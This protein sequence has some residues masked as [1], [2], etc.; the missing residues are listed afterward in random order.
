MALY[1]S[2]L[3]VSAYLTTKS[4]LEICGDELPEVYAYHALFCLYIENEKEYIKYRKIAF[5]KSPHAAEMLLGNVKPH[6]KN[7][8]L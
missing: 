5:E 8:K 2:R 4:L 1:E 3:Y 6:K 7:N